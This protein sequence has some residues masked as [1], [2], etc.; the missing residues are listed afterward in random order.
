[1]NY[2]VVKNRSLRP[3]EDFSEKKKTKRTVKKEFSKSNSV[4]TG[5]SRG[6]YKRVQWR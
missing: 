1:V 2:S 4:E 6:Y 5:I 3:R